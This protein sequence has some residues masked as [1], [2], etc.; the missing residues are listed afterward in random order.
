MTEPTRFNRLQTGRETRYPGQAT[1][2]DV[3]LSR[4]I[5][6]PV[7]TTANAPVKF[8][9]AGDFQILGLGVTVLG[10]IA[11]TGRTVIVGTDA[12]AARFGAVAM[13]TAAGGSRAVVIDGTGT[14]FAD[15]ASTG[16]ASVVTTCRASFDGG[17]AASAAAVLDVTYAVRET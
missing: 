5:E 9:I 3:V 13:V 12:T 6:L 14:A 15:W 7:G 16:E 11:T 4:R 2:A 8:T 17:T 1:Y 10:T